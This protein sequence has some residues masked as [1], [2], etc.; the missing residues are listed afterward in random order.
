MI[1]VEDFEMSEE[2]IKIYEMEKVQFKIERMKISE[3]Y[4]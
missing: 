1:G 3:G 4:G 2:M